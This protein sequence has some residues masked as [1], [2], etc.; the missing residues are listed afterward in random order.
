MNFELPWIKCG[1]IAELTTKLEQVSPQ[2]GKT[3]LQ[4]MVFLL[5][6]VYHVNVGYDFGFHTF[7]PFAAELLGDLNFAESMGFVTVKSV[8]ET[9]GNGYVI[10]SGDIIEGVLQSPTVS[11]FLSQHKEAIAALVK[12]FGD[13]TAKELELL[14]TIIY[15]N[16]EIMWDTNKLTLAEAISKIRELKPK[17]SDSEILNG[18]IELKTKHDV[19]LVFAA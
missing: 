17:F 4:K 8:E 5:Q 1:V 9:G 13:K 3:V 7:G 11:P 18:M 2:F 16:K 15:L 12:G 14:T 19:N 6:E 10:E